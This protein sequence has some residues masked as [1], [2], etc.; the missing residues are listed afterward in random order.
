ME[1]TIDSDEVGI[2]D[3]IDS[4]V[5]NN[6]MKYCVIGKLKEGI[7][8]KGHFLNIAFNNSFGI[9]TRITQIDEIEFT[10]SR[11]NCILIS[12]EYEDI[13]ILDLLLSMNV[14]METM[15]ITISGQD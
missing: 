15:K 4:F 10:S 1:I 12:S 2:F 6:Q 5:V 7:I 11:E 9:T 8:N 13:E 14:G 3:A